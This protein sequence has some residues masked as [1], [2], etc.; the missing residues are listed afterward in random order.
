M[1]SILE[2]NISSIFSPGINHNQCVYRDAQIDDALLELFLYKIQNFTYNTRSFESIMQ[3]CNLVD[4]DVFNLSCLPSC[5]QISGHVGAEDLRFFQNSV[6][7]KIPKD[8]SG[9]AD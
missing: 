4:K 7:D 3:I 6:N 1:R 5:D 2:K 8:I 9:H